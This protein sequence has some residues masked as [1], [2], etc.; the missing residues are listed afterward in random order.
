[1]KKKDSVRTK[2]TTLS[3]EERDAINAH[4]LEIINRNANPLNA[5]AEDFLHYQTWPEEEQ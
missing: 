5:E 3:G 2:L 1:M 4:D